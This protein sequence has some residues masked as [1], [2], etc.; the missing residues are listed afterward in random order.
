MYQVFVLRE[1]VGRRENVGGEHVSA[2]VPNRLPEKYY[3]QAFA[4]LDKRKNVDMLVLSLK[5]RRR[6]ESKTM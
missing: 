5:R 3:Y 1:R 2:S 6:D 4:R